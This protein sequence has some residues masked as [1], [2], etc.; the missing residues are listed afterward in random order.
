MSYYITAHR[1]GNYFNVPIEEKH[2]YQTGGLQIIGNGI[3]NLTGNSI[4]LG[5]ASMTRNDLYV[6][7]N[8]YTNIITSGGLS[9]TTAPNQISLNCVASYVRLFY[10]PL[11]LTITQGTGPQQRIGDKVFLK[12]VKIVMNLSLNDDALIGLNGN[13]AETSTFNT[14][15]PTGYAAISSSS[16]VGAI[17]TNTQSNNIYTYDNKRLNNKLFYKFRIMIVRFNDFNFKQSDTELNLQTY[18]ANWFNTI[19]L[20]QAIINAPD[21]SNYVDIPV[22]S[23]QSKML[24]EST[25]YN[26]KYNIIYDQIIELNEKDSSKHIEIALEPKKNLTFD[27]NNKPTDEDFNNVVGFIIPPLFY[28]TDMDFIS[29]NRINDLISNAGMIA[30]FT[31]N[32]K[33]TYYDI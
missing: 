20:P 10:R 13:D 19:F 3:N 29:F 15:Y 18:I 27:D 22:V 14:R 1:K 16:G 25:Q 17:T 4:N 30:D 23:N 21:A 12:N 32:I 9:K 28:K 7:K 2:I 24:R 31:T 33:Y 6:A 11:N 26:G 5:G 8:D